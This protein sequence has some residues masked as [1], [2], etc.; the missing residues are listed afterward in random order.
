MESVSQQAFVAPMVVC[1]WAVG[2]QSQRAALTRHT[3]CP[4]TELTNTLMC[5]VCV[6]CFLFLAVGATCLQLVS[7]RAA[8]SGCSTTPACAT[9]CTGGV[10]V[11]VC[12]C[13]SGVVRDGTEGGVARAPCL[14]TTDALESDTLDWHTFSLFVTPLFPPIS[15]HSHT[16]PHLQARRSRSEGP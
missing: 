9:Y 1:A 16:N 13:L 4:L 8:A 11:C 12:W 7:R 5:S 14:R 2:L 15:H 10:C 6:L 3:L